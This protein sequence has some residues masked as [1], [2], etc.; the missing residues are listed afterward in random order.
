MLLKHLNC[1]SNGDVVLKTASDFVG[2]VVGES[3]NKTNSILKLAAGKVLVIDE[4]YNLDDTMYGKQVLDVLVEKIQ[5][6][7][8]DDIAVLLLG[9][10]MPMKDMIRNQNPG[11]A[12]RFPMEYAFMFEDYSDEEFLRIW[13][14][15][16]KQKNVTM[17]STLL[18]SEK[19]VAILSRQRET[20]NFG[21]VGSLKLLLQSAISK[22]SIREQSD[23][24]SICIIPEDIDNGIITSADPFASLD[25]L[26]NIENIRDALKS[27]YHSFQ[28]ANDEGS[29]RPEVGH[30]VFRGAPGTGKTT[31]ARVMAEILFQLEIT[32]TN[33]IIETS[34]LDLTGQYLGQTKKVVG[35]KLDQAKGSVLFIDE[36]YELGR[37]PFGTEAMTT[38]LAAMTSPEYK[39]VVIIIAGYPRDI[40]DMLNRNVGLKSR[41]N[42]FYDFN[43]WLPEHCSKRYLDLA[44]KENLAFEPELEPFLKEHFSKIKLLAGWANARDVNQIWKDSLKVRSSRVFHAREN[45][46]TISIEDASKAF[47]DM[48]NARTAP[49]GSLSGIQPDQHDY[50]RCQTE[51]V[52][53]PFSH[54]AVLQ[55]M[56]IEELPDQED[57]KIEVKNDARDPGVS[58]QEWEEVQ[59]AMRKHEEQL[60]QRVIELEE[61]QKIHDEEIRRKLQ[62]QIEAAIK[63]ELRQQQAI[64]EQLRAISPCPAGFQWYRISNGWRCG[65]GSHYV[66]DAQLNTQFTHSQI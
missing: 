28:I 61:L 18:I 7:P 19:A 57:F 55:E 39:G 52:I 38:L 22:A 27:I 34:G 46:R 62:E 20:P 17:S 11:L 48:I 53:K 66:S 12:R 15:T 59:I 4:A 14:Q 32:A 30:F 24:E 60:A 63:E 1:L 8:S 25:H 13:I 45:V 37:G 64:Q 50:A 58:D 26:S 33:Q 2:S 36:A 49:E 5:G 23:P 21:N 42:Q 3:A 29:E 40:D 43:D 10:T 35:E 51:E 9:Y 31:V 41:F 65:G 56:S 44:L 47:A 6:T 16:C 54:E